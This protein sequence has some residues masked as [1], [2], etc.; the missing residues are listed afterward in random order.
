MA[1]KHRNKTLTNSPSVD[2]R[3]F[4]RA[5]AGGA[6]LAAGVI[7]CGGG[8]DAGGSDDGDGDGLDE[9]Q[10]G[11]IQED[12]RAVALDA[13]E[14]F[15]SNNAGLTLDEQAAAALGFVR[16]RPE[17]IDSD[18]NE[19]GVWAVFVDAVPL[20]LLF[21]RDPDLE[22]V[23]LNWLPPREQSASK[24]VP[25]SPTARLINTLGPFFADLT[26][27]YEPLLSANGYATVI[28]PGSVESLRAFNNDGVYIFVGAHAGNA[29]IPVLNAAGNFINTGNGRIRVRSEFAVWTSTVADR[30]TVGPFMDDIANGRLGIG[31]ALH[32]N[33]Q[34][35]ARTSARHYWFTAAFVD[36]YMNFGLD[37]LVWFNACRSHTSISAKF[38][39]ACINANA[40]IYVGWNRR[41]NGPDCLAC[42][43]FVL[44]RLIGSNTTNPLELPAQRPFDYASV[45]QD[46]AAHSLPSGLIYTTG[47]NFGLLAPSIKYV[48][49]NEV[50]DRAVLKGIFG[51]KPPDSE[52]KVTIGGQPSDVIDWQEN[53]IT[54]ELKPSGLGSAGDVQVIVRVHKSNVRLITEW[55][56]PMTCTFWPNHDSPLKVTGQVFA[57]FRADVGTYRDEAHDAPIKPRRAAIATRDS[58]ADLIAS[59]VEVVDAHCK[60]FWENQQVFPA[61][62]F[63]GIPNRVLVARFKVDAA[64]SK[65]AIG[66]DLA[67]F[68][69]HP[70]T[71]RGECE[72]W[73]DQDGNF[74]AAT[75]SSDDFTVPLGELYGQDWFPDP[76]GDPLRP[77]VPLNAIQIDMPM[78]A[79]GNSTFRIPAGVIEDLAA[80]VM[81]LEWTAVNPLYPPDPH[82]AI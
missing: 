62:F 12:A 58:D 5:S 68:P 34:P 77:D 20:M 80:G 63:S 67:G 22:P 25:D 37:S 74:H 47:T 38:V 61:Y 9:I 42:G 53:E 49:I 54:C 8:G 57:R 2:R 52:R 36:T 45:W 1:R 41:T 78:D 55:N 4:L 21:N 72:A 33:G 40:G 44:D 56:I 35:G 24:E 46:M 79:H 18:I 59:G 16:A 6:L 43:T 15:L 51:S 26:S 13:I 19:D 10:I 81:R 60:A 73:T 48:L 28:D 30:A 3:E 39:Q 76:A 11:T 27:R 14:A 7:G 17:F 82:G 50:Q 69:P 64:T 66:L 29:G 70:F 75:S 23:A 32:G 71:V 65:A 31:A